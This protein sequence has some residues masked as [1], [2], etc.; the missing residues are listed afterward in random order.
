VEGCITMDRVDTGL[1][2]ESWEQR[3]AGRFDNR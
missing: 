1:A 2:P 3:G